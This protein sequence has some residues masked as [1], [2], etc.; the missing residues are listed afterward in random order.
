MLFSV[1]CTHIHIHLR[2]Y[3]VLSVQVLWDKGENI[4]K[5]I[6]IKQLKRNQENKIC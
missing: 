2:V 3:A 6:N 1:N 4:V 5:Y